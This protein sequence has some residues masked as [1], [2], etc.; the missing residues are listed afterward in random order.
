VDKQQI[1]YCLGMAGEF[2]VAAE[3]LR[4]G[5]MAAVTHGNAKKA[6]VLALNGEKAVVV[7]VKSTTNLKWVLGNGLPADSMKPWVLVHFKPIDEVPEFYV[8][9]SSELRGLLI[10][11]DMEYRNSYLKRHGVEFSGVGVYSVKRSEVLLYRN[12]WESIVSAL[13]I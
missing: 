13:Q 5:L 7:E 10:P 9:T 1:K 3:L 2:Y 12:A 6:D 4:R 8:L 11:R